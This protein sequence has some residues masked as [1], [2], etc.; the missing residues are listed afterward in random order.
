MKD[1]IRMLHTLSSQPLRGDIV[2]FVVLVLF[3]LTEWPLNWSVG[4]EVGCEPSAPGPPDRVGS[5][6]HF[7]MPSPVVPL[8]EPDAMDTLPCA[9]RRRCGNFGHMPD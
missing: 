4:T 2:I 8:L 3:P 9:R 5:Q 6:L 1:Y 7:G